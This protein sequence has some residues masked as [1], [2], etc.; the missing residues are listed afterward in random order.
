MWKR[1]ASLLILAIIA[2]ESFA[3]RSIQV[4]S[5][6][7]GFAENNIS[8]PRIYIKNTGDDTLT[9][10]RYYYYFTTEDSKLP[11]FDDYY[12]PSVNIIIEHLHDSLYRVKYEF[13][14]N[15]FPGAMYPSEVENVIGLH[16]P[17]WSSWNKENDYSKSFGTYVTF[18]NANIPVYDENDS[19]L[20][21]IEPSD[22]GSGGTPSEDTDSLVVVPAG[23]FPM[24]YYAAYGIESVNIADRDTIKNGKVGSNT[25][26]EIGCEALL[27]S[28]IVAGGNLFLRERASIEGS[29]Q[30]AGVV[31][32]QNGTSISGSETDS[33]N[34]EPVQLPVVSVTPGT[35]NKTIPVTQSETV[36]PGAYNELI[37]YAGATVTLKPGIYSFKKFMLEPDVHLV[38]EL[39]GG[40][41]VIVNVQNMFRFADRCTVDFPLGKEYPLSLQFYT[42][43]TEQV[44]IGNQAV[45]KGVMCAPAAEISVNSHT[46]IFGGVY[47][48]RVTIQPNVTLCKPPV[49]ADL[50]HSEITFAPSFDPLNM[51][52]KT[53]ISTDITT[54]NVLPTAEDTD[55][56]VTI[57][58]NSPAT[59]VS[60]NGVSNDITILLTDAS[61]CS[62]TRYL[63]RVQ[64]SPNY[65]IYVNDNSPCTPGI[66]DGETW[67][68]AWKDL[69][70][71]LDNAAV[72]GREIWVAEGTY[73]PITRTVSADPK[74]ATFMVRSGVEING[75]FKGNEIEKNPT[76]S[77]YRTVLTGDLNGNDSLI[78]NWPPVSN[79]DFIAMSENCVCV[80][81]IIN[82]G[83]YTGCQ[84][85]GLSVKGGVTDTLH[86]ISG[87]GINC[88]GKLPDIQNCIFEKNYAVGAGAA[89]Y[90]L[91]PPK[92]L[93]NC[94]LKD[95]ITVAGA[96]AAFYSSS[97]KTF[98]ITGCIF[99]KNKQ[100]DS[101]EFSGGGLVSYCDSIKIVNTIFTR[102][103]AV[104]GGGALFVK[105]GHCKIINSTFSSNS[106]HDSTQSI[107]KDSGSI[108]VVNTILWNNDNKREIN[109]SNVTVNYSCITKGFTGVGNSIV[110]PQ[111]VNESQPEGPDGVYGTTDDG[112]RLSAGSMYID[113]GVS[114]PDIPDEDILYTERDIPDVGAYEYFI[115]QDFDK[116]FG[117]IDPA[118]RFVADDTITV[119]DTIWH[120]WYVNVYAISNYGLVGKI[121]LKK[122]KYTRNISQ[123]Y[124][125]LYSLDGSGN[126]ISGLPPVR[127]NL[128]KVG[129]ENGMLVFLTKTTTQGKPIVFVRDP[130][131]HNWTN[132]WAYVICAKSSNFR[133]ETPNDQF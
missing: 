3:A 74:S 99:D 47:G 113:R 27:K 83:N 43:Q 56:V 28:D 132:T 111:F 101:T 81:T 37:A 18:L 48:K 15:I 19:L 4:F 9:F 46:K 68:T 88:S 127:V 54:L 22:T 70:D 31:S 20:F 67:A 106:S 71:A 44:F 96:G 52:Y 23:T 118:G 69:Q 51:F 122:D 59:P 62:A 129:E 114:G 50:Y 77:P 94:L 41:P 115:V 86:F 65:M 35:V 87:A 64:R 110:N 45:F 120:W 112:L 98:T 33:M 57:N 124:T 91:E 100:I 6:D 30:I 26:I 12:S 97:G 89:I 103:T 128:Y 109:S 8:K 25:Y 7:E 58:G 80:V 72:T 90:T 107:S 82:N 116:V 133:A 121:T 104:H 95:N 76:G 24:G 29:V 39:N 61:G 36:Y 21:G 49:L 73:K 13:S 32:R 16:Y 78:M 2:V 42:T 123:F 108:S 125:Y 14:G 79:N 34:Y 17:D 126:E 1:C 60:L 117:Y 93:V 75:S 131:Y 130:L 102:N 84:L 55:I 66:E 92:D 10:L 11:V 105:R 5:R 85:K 63:L 53:I 119:I 38:A 40:T